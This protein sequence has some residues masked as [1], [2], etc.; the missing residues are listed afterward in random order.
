MNKGGF[1]KIRTSKQTT[2]NNFVDVDT[3]ELKD[4]DVEVKETSILVES[5]HDFVLMYVSQLGIIDGLDNSSMKV[6]HWC[7][8]NSQFN[9]NL[10]FLTSPIISEIAIFYGMKEQTVRNIV[11]KLKKGNILIQVKARSATYRVNPR[12]YWRGQSTERLKTMK[13]ILEV[14]CPGC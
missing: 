2:I 5:K 13:Y 6:L 1:R 10:V 3:G 14:E 11:S 8:M 12:Y 9:S 7:V 4:V